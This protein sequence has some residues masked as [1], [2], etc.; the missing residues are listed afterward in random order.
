MAPK[1]YVG[2]APTST[3]FRAILPSGDIACASYDRQD[4]GVEVYDGDGELIA[5]VP[6][7]NLVALVNED[8]DIGEDRSTF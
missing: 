7:S 3:M 8:A 1:R 4:D 6:Y 2:R 5:F